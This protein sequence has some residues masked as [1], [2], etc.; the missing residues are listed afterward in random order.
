MTAIGDMALDV[1]CV[2]SYGLKVDN[3]VILNKR[4]E[5]NIIH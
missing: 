1:L 4:L 5:W 3:F 2:F